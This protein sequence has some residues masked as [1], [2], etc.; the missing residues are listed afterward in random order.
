MTLLTDD[1][2]FKI[3]RPFVRGFSFLAPW[4]A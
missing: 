3:I 1:G 2:D 4:P